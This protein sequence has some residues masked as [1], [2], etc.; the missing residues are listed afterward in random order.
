MPIQR[1]ERTRAKYDCLY[2]LDQGDCKRCD[3]DFQRV[4]AERQR[5]RSLWT[6]NQKRC[7]RRLDHDTCE[8]TCYYL[9]LQ[10][11]FERHLEH[12]MD[13]YERVMTPTKPCGLTH[14]GPCN[15]GCGG[16]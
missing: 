12:L 14:D 8:E 3:I 11:G 10:P 15:I 7:P 6:D 13:V 16:Y 5:L 2:C 1:I 4:E 9:A